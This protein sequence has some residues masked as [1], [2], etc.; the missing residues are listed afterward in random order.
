MPWLDNISIFPPCLPLY[1]GCCC[2][3]TKSCPTGS[4]VHGIPQARILER[5]AISFSRGSSRI[6][7]QTCVSYTGRRILYHWVTR[8]AHSKCTMILIRCTTYQGDTLLGLLDRS[9]HCSV[10]EFS[11]L[12]RATHFMEESRC[13]QVGFQSTSMWS[14]EALCRASSNVFL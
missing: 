8:G 7:D 4:S 11:K 12:P 9:R 14:E 1:G 3:V 6:R 10:A 5:V 13:Q 2:L